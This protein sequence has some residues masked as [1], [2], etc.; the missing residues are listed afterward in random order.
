MA[1][2]RSSLFARSRSA[3]SVTYVSHDRAMASSL[4]RKDSSNRVHNTNIRRR[5]ASDISLFS[6]GSAGSWDDFFSDRRD[7]PSATTT[8]PQLP[9]PGPPVNTRP[10]PVDPSKSIKKPIDGFIE[11]MKRLEEER[12][13]QR[14]RKER[15][16]WEEE[17]ARRRALHDV[18]KVRAVSTDSSIDLTYSDHISSDLNRGRH[19]SVV[20]RHGSLHVPSNL[21]ASARG[22]VVTMNMLHPVTMR[23][24]TPRTRRKKQ[25]APEF[26][27]GDIVQLV[28]LR[29][30]T[31]YNFRHGPVKKFVVADELYVVDLMD[32]D[33]II[34]AI[35]VRPT[36]L[37]RYT[38]ESDDS[39]DVRG[40]I[41]NVMAEEDDEKRDR[42]RRKRWR[43]A[44]GYNDE[45]EWLRAM[46]LVT[47]TLDSKV[48]GLAH[49]II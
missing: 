46:A 29:R 14:L 13:R 49:F 21:D 22:D 47:K 32:E 20:T 41:K 25:N 12:R 38:G 39:D 6:T 2:V 42:R 33:G 11:R 9:P 15:E 3:R 48:Y 8:T 45:L 24:R 27:I 31:E 36:N 35:A 4:R 44:V 18:S 10:P 23:V 40:G 34:D 16:R 26:C 28:G 17:A 7:T 30:H 1:S 37:R 5:R 43:P 19:G